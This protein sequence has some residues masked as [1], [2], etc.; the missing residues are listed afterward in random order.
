[1][2]PTAD[3]EGRPPRRP[4]AHAL[5]LLLSAAS[6]ALLLAL[7]LVTCI[8]VV[9][10]YWFN[11]PLSGAYELTEIFLASL[12]F[13]ALPVTTS[14]GEHV[15]VDLMDMVAGGRITR[16]VQPLAGLL[17]ALVLAVFSW[18]L[19]LH[20]QRLAQDGA[21]SDSLSLPLAPVA[22]LAAAACGLA[23]LAAVLRALRPLVSRR[24][25]T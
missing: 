2:T 15:E 20:G 7:T 18:R 10:R 1:M 9:A 23:C 11:A 4:F 12:V 25:P 22:L 19:V 17:V 8:D 3:K 13:L 6:G 16:A 21:V 24:D 5:E 14:R